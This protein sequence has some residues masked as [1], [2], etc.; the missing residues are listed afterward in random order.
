MLN[1][2]THSPEETR[3][4]ASCIAADLGPGDVLALR[5]PLGSGKTCFVQ[6]VARGLGV[7]ERYITSPTF[8]LIRE[9]RGRLSLY[10][11]DLYRLATGPEIEH[12]GLEEYLEGD[13]VSAVEWAEKMEEMLPDRTIDVS[14][15]CLS[16]MTRKIVII[17]PKEK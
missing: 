13:G 3:K 1:Y 4:L 9:Y 5:G 10:H 2:T 12:L 6:G 16:E 14:F 7:A 17:F 11:I 8:V 15:D